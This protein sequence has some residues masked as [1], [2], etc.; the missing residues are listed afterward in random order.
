ML[1]FTSLSNGVSSCLTAVSADINFPILRLFFGIYRR[2]IRFAFLF[3]A[4][5]ENPICRN[6]RKLFTIFGTRG[7]LRKTFLHLV[8]VHRPGLVS[9]HHVEFKSS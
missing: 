6:K 4:I 3:S 1:I 5:P 2:K 8:T 7:I 9:F